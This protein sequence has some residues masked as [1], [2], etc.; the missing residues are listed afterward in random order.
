MIFC[1]CDTWGGSVSSSTLGTVL[2]HVS[3]I[4]GH[5]LFTV[6]GRN[7]GD[8][9]TPHVFP[10]TKTKSC[11]AGM[12]TTCSPGKPVKVTQQRG[13]ITL[14][15]GGNE[16]L[17]TEVYHRNVSALWCQCVAEL[18]VPFGFWIFEQTARVL[19]GWFFSGSPSLSLLPFFLSDKWLHDVT[20]T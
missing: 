2:F 8:Q 7:T 13:W 17:G 19:V 4:S 6:D 16:E 20:V 9:V 14:L 18:T 15:Q 5:A 3:L 11:R 10:L 12:Y 1:L